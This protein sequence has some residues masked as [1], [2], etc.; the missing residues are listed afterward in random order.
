MYKDPTFDVVAIREAREQR[1]NQAKADWLARRI[2]RRSDPAY[3]A[4]RR[5]RIQR[6]VRLVMSG[7]MKDRR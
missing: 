3:R 6:L 5:Q 7:K 1:A 4:M 2:A